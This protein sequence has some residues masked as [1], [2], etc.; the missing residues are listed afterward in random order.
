MNMEQRANEELV[1]EPNSDSLRLAVLT[2][3]S[4]KV[5]NVGPCENIR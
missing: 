5:R 3:L 2:E 1:E 4:F